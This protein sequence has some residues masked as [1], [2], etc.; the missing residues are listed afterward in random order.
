MM[1]ATAWALPGLQQATVAVVVG[2][3]QTLDA[4]RAAGLTAAD[5]SA[6]LVVGAFDRNG[7]TIAS[8]LQTLTNL[9]SARGGVVSYDVAANLPLKP[10]RYEIRAAV[11]DRQAGAVGSVYGYVEVPDYRATPVLLS[12]IV[13]DASP[14][15]TPAIGSLPPDVVPFVPTTMRT[16][17]PSDRVIAFARDQQGLVHSLVPGYLD[18]RIVNDADREVFHHEERLLPDA[19]G[20]NRATNL[21]LEVPVSSLGPGQYLLTIETRH[22]NDRAS[23]EVWFSVR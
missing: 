12:G 7:K 5:R 13:I 4:A 17:S 18:A 21:T 19:F 14:R 6:D 16:F 11:D 1:S 3:Q 15:R 9:P 20:A 10:G 2:V 8:T 22:G 23:R